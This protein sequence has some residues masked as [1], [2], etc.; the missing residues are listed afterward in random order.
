M[1]P[2]WI[3]CV[4][5]AA[6]VLVSSGAAQETLYNGIRL[7]SPWPPRVQALTHASPPMP[8]YLL[9]PPGVVPIDV[10]RQL[11]V[12]DFLIEHTTLT[13]TFHL[14][15][16]HAENPVL[17]P[18]KPWEQ[19]CAMAF[20][21]GV[22]YDPKDR[23]FKMWYMG[24]YLKATCYATSTD[25]I[26]W[27]KPSLDVQPGTNV[28]LLETQ[29]ALR[30]SSTVWLDLEEKDLQ[31]R[32]KMF[33]FLIEEKEVDGQEK[34]GYRLPVSFSPDGIH[35]TEAVAN[36]GPC[37]DRT[38]IFYNPFRSVWVYGLRD[39][40]K[41]V[42][43]TRRYWETPEVLTGL[44]WKGGQPAPWVGADDLDPPRDDL[45]TPCE[46]Y[47]LDAVAYESVLL[48]LF[49]IWRGQPANR[50][51]P[52]EVCVGFSRDGFHWY[53]PDRRPFIPVSERQGD[54]NWG[55]VQ[56]AGGCCLVKGD[57]LY[58]YVS[59][60]KGVPGSR[61]SGVCATGLATL[62]RDGFAS[63]DAGSA[64]GT[65]T[66]RPV[67]FSGKHL[68]VNVAAAAGELRVEA[69]DERGE[70][71]G[72]F[73]RANCEPVRADATRVPVRWKGVSDLSA[74][75]GKPVKFRFHLTNGCLYAFWVSPD[76]SGA[77]H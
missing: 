62:R 12:D 71:I 68:F 22:F 60:R 76:A 25:G 45:K 77:S 70:L 18:D 42:G 61:S 59:G 74:L 31:R 27:D 10:G 8:P 44:P 47:N 5:L 40:Q 56:S 67:R 63:M 73:S 38:S 54:W 75:A 26:R 49:S 29:G 20:S 58:F 53:R 4:G 48:G 6:V 13:R 11:L 66:T 17:K 69:L 24:G 28:V 7:P 57:K 16:Y 41:G 34:K 2:A 23:L 39:G 21:D 30:D 36:A 1:S 65:L 64:Q 52:N 32:Y 9:S 14:T 3:A 15:E 35:W 55:N 33:R 50:A 37:G 19:D 43:R 51:K 46:L 72:L